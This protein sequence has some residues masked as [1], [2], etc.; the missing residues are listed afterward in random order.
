M[1]REDKDFPGDV[2][3]RPLAAIRSRLTGRPDSEHQQVIIRLVIGLL[4]AS[5]FYTPLF[6]T[7]FEGSATLA[8]AR[9]AVLLFLVFSLLL[10][11][12]SSRTP[13]SR[14]FAG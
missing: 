4:F 2:L 14:R 5:Y 6:A 7:S 1:I 8:T 9:T 10:L 12:P 13:G 11:A 3:T